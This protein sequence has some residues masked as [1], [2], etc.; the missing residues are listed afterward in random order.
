MSDTQTQTQLRQLTEAELPGLLELAHLAGWNQTLADVQRMYEYA[1]EGSFGLWRDGKLVSTTMAFPYGKELGWL[2]MVLTHPEERGKGY[3][4]QVFERAVAWLREQGVAWMKLDASHF[5]QPLYANRGFVPETQMDRRL[6]AAEA[7]RPPAPTEVIIGDAVELPLSL[8]REG[9]GADRE[10]L[11]QMLLRIPAL[12]VATLPGGA[13]YAMLRPGAKAWQL[14]PMVC[15]SPESARVLLQ[16]ALAVTH[17]EPLQWDL[18]RGNQHAASLAAE[19]GFET[20]RELVRMVLAGVDNPPPFRG[21]PEL[22]YA[23]AG[24]DFG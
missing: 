4:G 11:L 18:D 19:Y 16:W 14:G 5:G 21:H 22:V 1:P 24:F 17:G 9:F 12:R 20:Q 23:I 8:E 2:A 7:P 10:R 3:A 15:N 13:G 6:L